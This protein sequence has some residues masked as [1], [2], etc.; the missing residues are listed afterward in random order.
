MEIGCIFDMDG[1]L[2]FS[3]HLHYQA[4]CK[5][6]AEEP[7]EVL[8]YNELAGMRTDTA[9]QK[10][11]KK[12]GVF[13]SPEKLK[14]LVSKKREYASKMLR[15][16]PPV[17]PGCKKV[18]SEFYRRGISLALA[19]SSSL[20]NVQLFLDSSGTRKYFSVILSGDDVENAKPDPEI[21]RKTRKSLRLLPESCFVV[22]DSKNGILGAQTDGMKVIGVIGQHTKKELQFF[23]TVATIS[24]IDE[25]LEMS[26]FQ[27]EI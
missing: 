13:L 12:S 7:V 24:R 21:F 9:I 6:L 19:S 18:I 22:E 27:S 15:E 4:F 20:Q 14:E 25:L 1:V 11:F 16:K 3:S 5:V 26:E 8:D 23:G 2:F 10:I 17:D